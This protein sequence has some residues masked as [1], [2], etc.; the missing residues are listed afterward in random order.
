MGCRSCRWRANAASVGIWTED[1]EQ[2]D[3]ISF[4]GR[5]GMDLECKCAVTLGQVFMSPEANTVDQLSVPTA[6]N[7]LQT[8]VCCGCA[9]LATKASR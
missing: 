9:K 7:L 3:F 8:D 6:S 4:F 1:F 2:D 5:S